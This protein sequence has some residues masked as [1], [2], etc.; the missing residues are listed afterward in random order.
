[1]VFIFLKAVVFQ[2]GGGLY[3]IIKDLFL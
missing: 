2:I 1:M 3:I